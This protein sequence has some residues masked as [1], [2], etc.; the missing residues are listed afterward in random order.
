MSPLF[1]PFIRYL[2]IC[3]SSRAGSGFISSDYYLHGFF[4]ASIKLPKDYTA[5]VVVAFYVSVRSLSTLKYFHSNSEHSC[6]KA[7][8]PFCLPY[9]RIPAAA[10]SNR[11]FVLG[12]MA[13]QHGF[14][15][16]ATAGES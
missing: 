6:P 9:W 11:W 1:L 10:L 12:H 13:C 3:S 16:S 14:S 2:I 15:I 7:R 4:S 5:G 8:D